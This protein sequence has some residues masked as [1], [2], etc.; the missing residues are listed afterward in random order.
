VHEAKPDVIVLQEVTG[1]YAKS[2]GTAVAADYPFNVTVGIDTAH[3]GTATW[4][5]YPLFDPQPFLL[6]PRGNQMHEVRLSTGKQT[7]TLYAVHLANAI[8][9][10]R[11]ENPFTAFQRYQPIARDADLAGLIER[12]RDL[13]GTFIIAG[14][15]NSAAGSRPYRSFPASWHDAFAQV[16]RGFG[17]TF[18]A[19]LHELARGGRIHLPLP[20]IRIDY[21]LT[22]ADIQPVHAWTTEIPVSDHLASLA[23]LDLPPVR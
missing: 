3:S 12:T 8:D 6:S 13:Q 10:S 20:V 15:F 11:D 5:R 18:P 22:S 2:F 14:D 1:D 19:P 17:N 7:L 9:N 16:G 23:D 21:I 4:S